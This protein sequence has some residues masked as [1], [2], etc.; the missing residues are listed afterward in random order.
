M[1]TINVQD[2]NSKEKYITGKYD[3]E[4]LTLPRIYVDD[5]EIKQDYTT[6][7]QIPSPGLVTIMRGSRGYGSIYVI[8]DSKME[9][10]YNLSPNLTKDIIRLQP[11]SYKVIFRI[12]GLRSSEYTITKSFKV[13]SNA[14]NL[15]RIR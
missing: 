9:W 7:I 8:K 6:K 4:I 12:R 11:G 3:L 15:V 2:I 13:N 10:V 1:Q 5:V 14:S